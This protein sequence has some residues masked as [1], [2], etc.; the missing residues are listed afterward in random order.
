MLA[1]GVASA[2]QVRG[3]LAAF[4]P[5]PT[6]GSTSRVYDDCP[7]H[8]LPAL[9]VCESCVRPLCRKC[10]A[11][12][13]RCAECRAAAANQN[14]QA[15]IPGPSGARSGSLLFLVVLLTIVMLVLNWKGC[16]GLPK[17]IIWLK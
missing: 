11:T 7:D 2:H 13:S 9:S 5:R 15:H 14:S 3:S 6:C 10:K 17:N 4:A 16:P 12:R 1:S 8:R